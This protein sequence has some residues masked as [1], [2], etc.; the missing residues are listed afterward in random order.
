MNIRHQNLAR[1]PRRCQQLSLRSHARPQPTAVKRVFEASGDF[2]MLRSLNKIRN[3]EWGAIRSGSKF[4]ARKRWRV[5]IR[6]NSW[7]SWRFLLI[8]G[9]EFHEF[10]EKDQK[11]TTRLA[12]KK[13]DSHF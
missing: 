12:P 13:F 3:Q 11:T 7:I 1:R 10:H 6:A 8:L 2:V 9:H 5:L 4:D